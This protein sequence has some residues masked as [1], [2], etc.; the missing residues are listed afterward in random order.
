MA[1]FADFDNRIA[2]IVRGAKAGVRELDRLGSGPLLS[3]LQ[4]SGLNKLL[5]YWRPDP[6]VMRWLPY[7]SLF[8]V[9]HVRGARGSTII[10]CTAHGID[11]CHKTIRRPV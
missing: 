11:L 4:G 8:F 5:N 2:A 9:P 7:F 10:N 3:S 6:I 1:S